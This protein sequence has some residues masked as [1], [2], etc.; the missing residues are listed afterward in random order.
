VYLVALNQI[1]FDADNDASKGIFITTPV[2][3]DNTAEVTIKGAFENKGRHEK[4]LT[5]THTIFD[6]DGNRFKELKKNF[7]A[8]PGEKVSFRQYLKNI[9][10]HRLWSL[11]DPYLYRVV[12][13]ITEVG[14]NIIL[15]EVSNP[16]G[17]RYFKFDA[18]QG[19]FLN[20]KHVK[21]VGASRHQDFKGMGNAL[22][23]DIHVR[24]VELLKE[25]GGN[26]LRIAHYPQDPAILEACDRLGIL[27]SVETPSGNHI[28]ESEAFAGNSLAIQREMIRQNFNHPSVIIWAYMNEVLLRPPYEKGSPQQEAYFTNVT[29]LAQQM[30][31]LTRKED[32]GR[33]T[34]IPN[35]GSFELYNRVQLTKIPMLVGW[36]LYLGWYSRSFEGFGD[37]LDKHRKELPD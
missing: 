16:L 7:K 31:V 21:L 5:V 11:E 27:A 24:D 35:H 29:K 33:Y 17:F 36:N 18:A 3:T 6:A 4:K 25:M 13:T 20:G 34:M 32:A 28:T 8:K 2:V 26:F 15:D 1:H 9:K 30:E 12:S 14:T 19:F 37:F 22:T 23:D 10:V